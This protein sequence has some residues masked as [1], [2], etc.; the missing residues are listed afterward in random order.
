MC[1]VTQESNEALLMAK[2]SAE[3][4]SVEC[5][6]LSVECQQLRDQLAEQQCD[7]VTLR[8]QMFRVSHKSHTEEQVGQT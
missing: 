2:S 8:Q 3:Q 7:T 5:Q 4:L 1:N 6:Q